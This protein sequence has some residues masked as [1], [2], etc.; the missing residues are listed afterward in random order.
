VAALLG[1]K[2]LK[3]THGLLRAWRISHEHCKDKKPT[4]LKRA[5][6][7]LQDG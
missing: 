2:R 3:S 5:L 7:Q 1:G 6:Q 4:F